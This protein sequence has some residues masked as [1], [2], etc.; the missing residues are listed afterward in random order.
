ML[1]LPVSLFLFLF[2]FLLSAASA[3][4][5]LSVSSRRLVPFWSCCLVCS[6]LYALMHFGD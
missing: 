4:G 3:F 6:F 2:L 5:I 1:F